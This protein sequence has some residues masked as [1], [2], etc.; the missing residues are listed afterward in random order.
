M[1]PWL[2]K[3]IFDIRKDIY[4]V[5]IYL[6]DGQRSG[7]INMMHA[8]RLVFPSCYTTVNSG[9]PANE[10]VDVSNAK[11]GTFNLEQDIFPGD[12]IYIPGHDYHWGANGSQIWW[13]LDWFNWW[14]GANDVLEPFF[15]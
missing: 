15:P 6:C 9:E 2:R 4:D 11:P 14:N 3:S 8:V 5:T 12:G 10:K 7:T 13:R 1:A